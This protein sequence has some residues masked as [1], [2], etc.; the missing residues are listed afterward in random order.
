MSTVTMAAKD[1]KQKFGQ[2]VRDALGG[3]VDVT[4]NGTPT[5]SVI[6][7]ARLDE[8][9]AVEVGGSDVVA[10]WRKFVPDG[11]MTAKEAEA[12]RNLEADVDGNS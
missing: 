6:P 5:V 2:L 7:T 4:H 12:Q 10:A 3:R 11:L 9:L 1:A 8:L